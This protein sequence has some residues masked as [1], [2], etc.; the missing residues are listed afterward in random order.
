VITA[1]HELLKEF[2]YSL[3]QDIKSTSQK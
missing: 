2:G 1:V 3:V